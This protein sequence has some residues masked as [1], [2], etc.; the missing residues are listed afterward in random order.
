MAVKDISKGDM[1]KR[2]RIRHY[3]ITKRDFEKLM[4]GEEIFFYNGNE[5]S[6]YFSFDEEV[7]K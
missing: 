6:I 7:L 2:K 4:N 3:K 5:I 1:G